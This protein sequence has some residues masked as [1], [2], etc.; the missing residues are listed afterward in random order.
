MFPDRWKIA[1]VRS[2]I[3]KCNLD[4]INKHYRPVSNL[5]FIL[6]LIEKGV[7]YK[8]NEHCTYNDVQ[9]AFQSA[10][11]KNHSCK[12]AILKVVND[13]LLTMEC[14]Q[15]TGGTGNECSI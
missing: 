7:L 14:T 13:M 8:L 9:S 3:K 2:L 15:V 4:R 11:K 12:T 5:A 6:K 10:Y 1:V